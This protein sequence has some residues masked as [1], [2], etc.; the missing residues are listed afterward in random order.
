MARYLTVGHLLVE[1]VV[2][3]DGTR[4]LER[5]GGDAVYAAIG[6]RAFADDVQ[7]VVRRGRGFPE[8]LAAE[9]AAAGLAE[10]LI[11]SEHETIRFWIEMGIEDGA[12][13]TFQSGNYADATPSPDEIP[14]ALAARLDAVHIAPVPFD[15]MLPLVEWARSRARIVTVDPH[16]EHMDR[17]WEPVLAEIDAFLPSRAEAESLLGG[18]PGPEEAVRAL[19][20]GTAAIKLGAEGSVG[21]RDD[22][23]VRLAAATGNAVDPTGC[24]DAFCGGFLVG[25]A[26]TGDLGV[27]MAYGTVAAGFVASDHGAAHALSIDRSEALERLAST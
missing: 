2:L 3:R 23:V 20:I 9:L 1:D 6:A 11:P 21:T 13:Y 18:W 12:R 19:G 8:V 15:E 16:Y 25:L 14:E 24:G 7:M 27:A 5:L 22:E 10:G 17:D 26:E 4:A